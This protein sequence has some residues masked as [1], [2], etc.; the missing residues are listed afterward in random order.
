MSEQETKQQIIYDLL[1]AKNQAKKIFKNDWC[2][3]MAS[4]KARL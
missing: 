3:F 4:I 2:F 1:N